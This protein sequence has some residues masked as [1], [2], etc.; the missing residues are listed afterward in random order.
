VRLRLHHSTA[1]ESTGCLRLNEER[2]L[3]KR[4]TIKIILLTAAVLWLADLT[5]K[6]VKNISYLERERCVLY[7]VLPKAGFLIY[8]YI[9]ETIIMVLLGTYVAVVV[10]KWFAGRSR[11]FPQNPVT[12]F[13]CASVIP[14]CSCAA[15]PLIASM[16]G[17]MRFKTTMA[18]VLAA[19]LL[20][21]QIIALSFSMAGSTY[22]FLRIGAS[23]A[24]VMIVIHVLDLFRNKDGHFDVTALKPGCSSSCAPGL[25]D[26]YLETYHL[27]WKLLPYVGL[28]GVLGILVEY[29]GPRNSLLGIPFDHGIGGVAMVSLIGIPLYLCNGADV[30]LLRP[31]LSHGFPVGTA[32]VFSLTSTAICTASIA[33]LVKLI[34]I[35]M[36]ALL[37]F[38]LLAVSIVLGF[39]LNGIT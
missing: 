12:A 17:K 34:G 29:L 30:L 38:S 6:T 24:L 33:M 36:S 1:A 16:E 20:S 10:G 15:L 26:V 23:F 37:V 35:R 21:P 13:L 7:Q 22:A 9:F 11:F 19:P 32:V 28:A 14:V 18:F 8:E 31:L 4:L 27:F 25:Q 5:Y 2:Q 3:T 39:V